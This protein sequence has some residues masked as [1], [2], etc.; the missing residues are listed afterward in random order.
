MYKPCNVSPIEALNAAETVIQGFKTTVN[1]Y[2]ITVERLSAAIKMGLYRPGDQ[3][4]TE[5]DLADI[6]GVSRTTVREAIRVL[7]AQGFLSV[8]RGR[9]GGTFVCE[10]LVLPS[11]CELKQRLEQRGT[12]LN[13]ILDYRLV[14]EPGVAELAA[15][16]AN[17]QQLDELQSLVDR[18][19][20]AANHFNDHRHLDTKFHLL[21]ASAT[22]SRRLT[23]IVAGIHAELSDLLA[24]IP[25][26][27]AACLSS[28]AQH[29]Q[30]LDALREEQ[31]D[32]A[33][34]LMA[35]HIDRTQRLLNGL[36]G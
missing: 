32:L 20:Q 15:Q 12:T 10:G 13:E 11:V 14:M 26:S 33:R 9:T 22:Q 24:I 4:P 23:T 17:S 36:L 29:Q 21:I 2:E 6:M 28:T 7:A 25:H 18:M 1:A 34:Q 16:R 35:D 27:P 30:I 8:K 19:K 5:R 3:L 31:A